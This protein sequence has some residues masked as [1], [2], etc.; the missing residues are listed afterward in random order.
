MI[1]KT[2][3]YLQNDFLTKIKDI[4]FKINSLPESP[5]ILSTNFSESNTKRLYRLL[6]VDEALIID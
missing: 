2:S 5:N 3:E 6:V 1:I 4:L